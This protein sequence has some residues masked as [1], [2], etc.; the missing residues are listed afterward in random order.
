M[1]RYH[2]NLDLTTGAR[3]TI[4]YSPE[5]EAAADAAPPILPDLLPYQFF[6]MLEIS[7][8]KNDLDTYIDALTPPQ[9]IVARAKLEHSLAFHRDNDLMLAA[10]AGLGLTDEQLDTL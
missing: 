5:E 4:A 2:V 6:A 10:Q 3:T 7:G 9:N 1:T 8:K